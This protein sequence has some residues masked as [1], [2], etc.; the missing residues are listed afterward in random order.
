MSKFLRGYRASDSYIDWD[1]PTISDDI[2][3]E[4]SRLQ[5]DAYYFARNHHKKRINKKWH[6]RYGISLYNKDAEKFLKKHNKKL[7]YKHV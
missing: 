5:W 3:Q 1:L 2:I 4:I 7:I 6:K